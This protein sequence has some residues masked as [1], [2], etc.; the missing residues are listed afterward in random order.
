MKYLELLYYRYYQFQ[1]RMGNA[2]VAPFITILLIAFTTM[3]YYF[4]FFII[5]SVL[6]PNKLPGLSW[7][8]NLILLLFLIVLLYF[9]LVHKGKYKKILKE[10]EKSI[11]KKGKWFAV[12]FALTAFVLFN[13]GF[14][15]KILQNQGKF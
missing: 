11:S 7:K 6:Y 9:M 8:F 2:D 15:I 1:V 14:I 10:Q 13:L 5:L 12:L 3:L 4:D